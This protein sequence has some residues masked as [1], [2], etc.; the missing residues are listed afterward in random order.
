MKKSTLIC[1]LSA[2][3]FCLSGCL[4]PHLSS[5]GASQMIIAHQ[6]RSAV[7]GDTS[8]MALSIDAFG[9]IKMT[10]RNIKDGFSGGATASLN[11]RPLGFSSPLYLEAALGGKGGNASLECSEGGKCNDRYT[12]WLLSDAGKKKYSF[13]SVQERLGGGAEFNIGQYSVLGASAGIQ[14]FEGGGDFDDI[15]DELGK[16]MANNDDEGFGIKVYSSVYAGARLGQNGII[17]LEGDVMWLKTMNIGLMLNYFHPS[18]FHG[19]IF[20]A[21]KV[22]YGVNF[23]KTF[24]F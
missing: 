8:A 16:N 14:I 3:T 15:R 17:V 24:R 9:G 19:G 7:N 21:E 23:G 2:M 5:M 12:E 4:N 18:G 13:W 1:L 6:P 11:F 22:G 10:G 20:A